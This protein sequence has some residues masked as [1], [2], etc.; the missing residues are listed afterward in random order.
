MAAR[1]SEPGPESSIAVSAL[2]EPGNPVTSAV[3]PVEIWYEDDLYGDYDPGWQRVVLGGPPVTDN[4]HFPG[5]VTIHLEEESVTL[6]ADAVVRWRVAPD[7]GYER[8]LLEGGSGSEGMEMRTYP[9]GSI[10]VV[11]TGGA[12]DTEYLASLVAQAVGALVPQV[13]ISS[14]EDSAWMG[15]IEG[16]LGDELEGT[17][18][19]RI[20]A[21]E[22][23][24]VTTDSGWRL[25]LLD[26]LID[27]RDRNPGNWF[28]LPDGRVAGIDHGRAWFHPERGLGGRPLPEN[29]WPLSQP[30]LG[31][32]EARRITAALRALRPEFQRLG[33]IRSWRTTMANWERLQGGWAGG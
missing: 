6:P 13:A 21:G 15:F 14:G 27:N 26:R 9:D 31:P 16:R 32:G 4:P 18:A 12:T 25:A 33:R 7:R 1:P 30:R 2:R 11:K 29:W 23:L 28:I 17:R 8:E 10:V 5:R 19:E 22:R 24:A 20:A 3:R